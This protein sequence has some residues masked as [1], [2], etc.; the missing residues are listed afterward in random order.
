M[1]IDD[2]L[3]QL[4]VQVLLL[5]ARHLGFE[6][7][8]EQIRDLLPAMSDKEVLGEL[9]AERRGLSPWRSLMSWMQGLGNSIQWR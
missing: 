9:A 7:T 5:L 2:A 6:A 8:A 1:E 4:R 3:L